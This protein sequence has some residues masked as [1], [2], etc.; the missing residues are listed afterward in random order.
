MP[1]HYIWTRVPP[2]KFMHGTCWIMVHVGW[3]PDDLPIF[4]KIISNIVLVGIVL[5][6]IELFF[7]EG[8]S[9]H[10]A[11]YHITPTCQKKVLIL[12]S[13]KIKDVYYSHTFLGDKKLYLCVPSHIERV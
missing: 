9:S 11:S 3:Q 10:I 8:I 13:L 6:E 5:L 12:S 7:T 2:F 1:I 4:A